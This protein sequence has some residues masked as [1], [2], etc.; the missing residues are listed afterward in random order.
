MKFSFKPEDI[1]YIKILYKDLTQAPAV[2]KAGIKMITDREIIASGKFEDGLNITTPQEI[3]LSIVCNDGIYRTMT[4]LKTVE[5]DLPYAFFILE[6]PQ[7]VEYEQNREY[8]RVKANYKCLCNLASDNLKKYEAETY[9][10]SAS[11]ISIISPT[12]FINAGQAELLIQ[13]GIK[14]VQAKALFVRSEKFNKGYRISFA[15]TRISESD[16]DFISQVCIKKQLEQRRT[17]IK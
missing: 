7:N 12:E 11:G 10:I 5:N 16:R 14:T 8:F 17:A 9:D 15:Y 3:S 13:F 6:T 4:S 2:T 1:K